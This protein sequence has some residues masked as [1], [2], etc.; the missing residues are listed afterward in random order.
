[1]WREFSSSMPYSYF[2]WRELGVKSYWPVDPITIH[3]TAQ[4]YIISIR[5]SLLYDIVSLAQGQP[6]IRWSLEEKFRWLRLSRTVHWGEKFKECFSELIHTSHEM[7][8]RFCVMQIVGRYQNV[9][10]PG[11]GSKSGKPNPLNGR[12][13]S[14]WPDNSEFGVLYPTLSCLVTILYCTVL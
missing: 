5:A 1:M 7:Q 4:N 2:L 11:N 9:W 8:G 14:E 10:K 6:W 12:I 3:N 13:S